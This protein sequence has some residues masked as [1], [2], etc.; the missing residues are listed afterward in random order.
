MKEEEVWGFRRD[1]LVS[2][3]ET[4][5]FQLKAF[6]RFSWSLNQLYVAERIEGIQELS[7]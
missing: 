1:D 3:L 7:G 6:A 2:I 4:N 5:G